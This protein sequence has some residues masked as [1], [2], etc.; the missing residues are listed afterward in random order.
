MP[1]PHRGS[2]EV[3]RTARPVAGPCAAPT[4]RPRRAHRHKGNPGRA[5]GDPGACARV[6]DSGRR[7]GPPSPLPLNCRSRACAP[8]L[9]RTAARSGKFSRPHVRALPR[10]HP[11]RSSAKRGGRTGGRRRAARSTPGARAAW[12]HSKMG[13][14]HVQPATRRSQPQHALFCSHRKG[15]SLQHSYTSSALY[16]R[17]WRRP[18]TRTP[19]AS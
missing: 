18:N 7:A 14:T 15:P 3:N 19:A 11:G 5:Q 12:K 4:R 10:A 2:I 6:Y 9:F 16:R 8:R 13:D 17:A 1:P